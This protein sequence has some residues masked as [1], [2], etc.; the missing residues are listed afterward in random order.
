MFFLCTYVF[1]KIGTHQLGPR[2]Q[3]WNGNEVKAELA[4]SDQS[5][6]GLRGA[7]AMPPRG[8]A[9]RANRTSDRGQPLKF[10]R[11]GT[12]F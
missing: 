11:R 10:Y 4:N 9:S 3:E 1:R 2:G 6:H 7:G 12:H 5:V 8:P